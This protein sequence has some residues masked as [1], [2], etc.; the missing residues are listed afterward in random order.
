MSFEIAYLADFPGDVDAIASWLHAEWGWF[1]PGSTLEDRREKLARHLNRD[2]L[3]LAIVARQNGRPVGTA[4]L[5]VNDMDSR[6]NLTP[7]LASVYV[8]PSCRGRGLGTELITR[9]ERE[10]LRLG[11]DRLYLVTFDGAAF[12]AARGWTIHER[13]S[14][15]TEP[16]VVMQMRL[17]NDAGRPA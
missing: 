4:A 14:Y 17:P 15:R 7:W 3:P 10:A 9:I 12:Y 8:R 6:P 5:R 13:T 16:V 1:T 2:V 11:F